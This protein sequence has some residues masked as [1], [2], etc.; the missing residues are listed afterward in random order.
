[1]PTPFNHL[2]IARDLL[3]LAPTELRAA[4]EAELPAFLLG[5]IAPDVQ[6]L[7]GQTREATHFFPVPLGSAPPALAVMFAR[8]PELAEPGQLPP[9]QA[10][11]LA[12][13]LCHLEFD[14]RWI[15]DIFDPVFGMAQTWASFPE[16]IYLHNALR[17]Y[18]D[19]GDLPQ[20]P[21]ATGVTLC[22]AAPR[23]WLPFVT[24]EAL[25]RW[26][27][28]VAGQLLE[29]GAAQ[30]VEVFARRMQVEAADFARLVRSPEAMQRRVFT[31]APLE[32]VQAYRA[33][34][35][36]ASLQLLA[37]YRAGRFKPG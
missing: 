5:N 29:G 28:E 8:H 15:R 17:A 14:Q 11:F 35:L 12:G 19:A 36:A 31:R 34:A 25:G 3:L 32:K 20:L 33:A 22:A 6:T 21:P 10:A 9:A 24:D 30:T 37:D 1:M 18:W 2:L 13:Y 23:G 16:R 26:R 27:D 7:S 4:L